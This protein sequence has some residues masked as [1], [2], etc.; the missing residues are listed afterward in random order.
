MN[1]LKKL[2]N[3]FEEVISCV[4]LITMTIV[5]AIQIALRFL[6]LPLAWT[7]EMARYMFVWLIYMSCALGVKRRKHIKVEFATLL[8]K[9]KGNFILALI[10]NIIFM[11]FAGI[12]TYNGVILIYKLQFIQGQLSPAMRIPM[13]I[14]YSSFV[15][16]SILMFLRLL[17][18]TLKFIK[19]KQNKS[20]T[21]IDKT[22]DN[23]I[24]SEDYSSLV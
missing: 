18:D 4:L 19:E 7:E 9:E 21:N 16:G 11:I 24:K 12:I 10:S 6:G 8:F 20:N 3:N 22:D 2:D 15:I 1:L 5:I 23:I 13:S 14:P 17:Q